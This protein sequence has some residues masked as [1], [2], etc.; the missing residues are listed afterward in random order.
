MSSDITVFIFNDSSAVSITYYWQ[1]MSKLDVGL[2]TTTMWWVQLSLLLTLDSSSLQDV[3]HVLQEDVKTTG[4]TL[5]NN[6]QNLRKSLEEREKVYI[7]QPQ[8]KTVFLHLPLPVWRA[9]GLTCRNMSQFS[10]EI[11]HQSMGINAYSYRS[12]LQITCGY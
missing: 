5:S 7:S 12:Q 4:Q 10:L 2:L 1:M 9:A 6:T 8:V 3:G 11:A